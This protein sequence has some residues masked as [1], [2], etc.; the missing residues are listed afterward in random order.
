VA[1]YENDAAVRAAYRKL[2]INAKAPL[3]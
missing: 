2:G 3:R 1:A